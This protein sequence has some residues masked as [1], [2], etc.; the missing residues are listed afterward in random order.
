MLGIQDKS[1]NSTPSLGGGQAINRRHSVV[2]AGRY[3]RGQEKHRKGQPSQTE[4]VGTSQP[5]VE[6]SASELSPK[7]ETGVEQVKKQPW[8]FQVEGAARGGTREAR[9]QPVGATGL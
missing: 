9:R 2:G 7:G 5:V 1:Q 8:V 6:E 4:V 3:H